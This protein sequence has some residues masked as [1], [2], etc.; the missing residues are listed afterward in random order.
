MITVKVGK[1]GVSVYITASV[2]GF[3]GSLG[4]GGVR[5]TRT[6]SSGN[7]YINF[8]DYSPKFEGTIVVEGTTIY[9]GSI[10]AHGTYRC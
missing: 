3:F 5:S 7:A 4:A 1:P 8:D 10:D 6:D 9:K 2:G